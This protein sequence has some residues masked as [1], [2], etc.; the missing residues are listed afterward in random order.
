MALNKQVWINQIKEGFYPERSF[1]EKVLDYS[2]FVENDSLHFASA[3]NVIRF[4]IPEVAP[5]VKTKGVS[6]VSASGEKA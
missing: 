4:R 3:A 1:L 2:G 5:V 6:F